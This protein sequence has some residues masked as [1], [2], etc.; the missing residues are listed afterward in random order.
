MLLFSTPVNQKRLLEM[1]QNIWQRSGGWGIDGGTL[2]IHVSAF[3]PIRL[4][5]Y[6]MSALYYHNLSSEGLKRTPAKGLYIENYSNKTH[7]SVRFKNGTLRVQMSCIPHCKVNYEHIFITD[8]NFFIFIF[9][10]LICY[11]HCFI[12]T[13][14]GMYI[15]L[16]VQKIKFTF[17]RSAWPK[18]FY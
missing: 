4:G 18:L 15:M 6:E 3:N 14:E 2:A 17:I 13:P 9:S 16:A 11:C 7:T 8:K 10:C 5:G 1:T 12:V